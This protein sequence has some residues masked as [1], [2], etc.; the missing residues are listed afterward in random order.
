MADRATLTSFL[1]MTWMLFLA[2]TISP[3]SDSD[4]TDSEES[5]SEGSGSGKEKKNHVQ[6]GKDVEWEMVKTAR[7]SKDGLLTTHG[8]FTFHRVSCK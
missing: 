8:C 6:E 4:E 3:M 2:V 7:S 5:E 1:L